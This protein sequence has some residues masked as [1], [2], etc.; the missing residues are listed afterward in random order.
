MTSNSFTEVPIGN[1]DGFDERKTTEDLAPDA[2]ESPADLER[3]IGVELGRITRRTPPPMF[4]TI[5]EFAREYVPLTYVVESVIRGGSLYTLTAPTGAGKTAFSVA[6]ALAVATGRPDIL[7]VEVVRGRIAYLVGE[8]PDDVRMRFMIAAS[9]LNVDLGELVDDIVILDRR[10]RP[11]SICLEIAK[12]AEQKPFALVIVDTLAAFFDGRDMND[13]VEGGQFLRRM[14]PLTR[15]GGLPAVVVA[16]HP[17]KNAGEGALV[18]YG[19][20]AILNEVDGNLTL[21]KQRTTRLVELHW[22][23]KLRGLD[24][25]PVP[26]R[27]E[28]TDS[29]D[30]LDA[31]GARVK[32]PT[33]RPSTAQSVE[34]RQRV[35]VDGDRVLLLAMIERPGATVRDLA[36]AKQPGFRSRP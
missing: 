9:Y 28:I 14:R 12:L 10:E 2:R 21:W 15:V 8:N 35:D 5:G 29:P 24:F 7:G 22:Q 30:V 18:P 33:L 3:A 34:E 16:A 25:Q 27:F 23:G 11:E 4:R 31:K 17:V 13:A 36:E 1:I 19:S 32:L 26:F 20:G 6:I